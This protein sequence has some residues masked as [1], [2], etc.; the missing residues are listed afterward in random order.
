[1]AKPHSDHDKLFKSAFQDI[2]SVREFLENFLEPEILKDVNLKK[3]KLDNTNYITDKN[4]ELFSDVVFRTTFLKNKNTFI[5]LLEHKSEIDRALNVQILRYSLEILALDLQ[6]NRPYS[7]VL[8]I[9]IYHGKRKNKPEPL[10]TYFKDLPQ[11][12][13]QFVPSINF[14]FVNL[15]TTPNERLLDLSDNTLLKSAFLALKNIE[16][17]DFIKSNFDDFISF[18]EK[19]SKYT[20]FLKKILLYLY[21]HSNLGVPD[22][23][24]LVSSQKNKKLGMKVGYAQKSA[25]A[26]ILEEGK[27]KNAVEVVRECWKEGLSIEMTSRISK[28]SI[29]QVKIYFLKFEKEK[30]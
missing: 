3:L 11:Y 4:K 13:H 9:I 20:G 15:G 14:I 30:K 17:A 6:A 22:I 5:L 24:S 18:A 23:N 27:S 25:Y 28:I 10:H 19:N 21:E 26:E 29:E 12:L 1:M 16:N 8:P 7:F 2:N